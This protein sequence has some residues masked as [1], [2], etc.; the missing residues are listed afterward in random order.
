MGVIA[1]AFA[2][3]AAAAAVVAAGSTAYGAYQASQANKYQAAVAERNAQ[4]EEANRAAS[5]QESAVLESNQ[6]TETGRR[7]GAALAAQG[8][9]GIDVGYG[10]PTELR[11]ALANEGDLDALTI[12]YN[13]TRKSLA[14]L[15]TQSGLR[16]EASGYRAAGK[17]AIIGGVL[18]TASSFLS[19]ASSIQ[20]RA[21]A[22]SSV[23]LGG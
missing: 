10:S 3:L 11:G 13:A 23:G 16:A 14:Y 21:T 19:S 1:P 20:S 4:V 9:S 7:I 15:N 8:A 17:N 5:L 12:R 2:T 6:R 18:D 22:R